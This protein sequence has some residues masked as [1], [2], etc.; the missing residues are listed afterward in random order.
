MSTNVGSSVP[1]GGCEAYVELQKALN[2]VGDYRLSTS[3]NVLRWAKTNVAVTVD[4]LV[5]TAQESDYAC[6]PL[7]NSAQGI[8]SYSPVASPMAGSVG[9]CCFAM[10]SDLETSN[11][12]E[13]SGLNAEEQS[14]IALLANWSV[15]QQSGYN[16]EVYSFYDAMIILRANN[17]VELIQ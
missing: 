9:S 8:T 14:D 1:N 5:T 4:G 7:L 15:A 11:G 10:S 13:I 12:V 16:L 2:M 3:C 6:Y 17:V